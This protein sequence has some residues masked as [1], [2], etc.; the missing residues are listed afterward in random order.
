LAT[1]ARTPP[2][3]AHG[4]RKARRAGCIGRPNN[5]L[6]ITDTPHHSC[7]PVREQAEALL[8]VRLVFQKNKILDCLGLT[9]GDPEDMRSTTTCDSNMTMRICKR[10]LYPSW[11]VCEARL[12]YD[13][14]NADEHCQTILTP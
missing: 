14:Q 13:V 7:R 10:Y 12:P 4:G 6:K 5:T 11:L 8:V 9:Q 1:V 3:A 2:R